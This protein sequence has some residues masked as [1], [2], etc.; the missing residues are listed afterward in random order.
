M[1]VLIVTGTS[2]GVGKTV[3]TA[4]LAAC[5]IAN[6]R[7]VTIVKLVQT[8]LPAG[9]PGDVAEAGRLSGCRHLVELLRYPDPLAPEAAA[10]LSRR[11]Y[12]DLATLRVAVADLASTG[13]LVLVE[14]AGGLL[15]RFDA[16]GRTL[17]DLAAM[18]S[19]P[20]VVV[21]SA[22]LGTLNH[23]ALTLEALDRRRIEL[24]G[25]ILG[26]WP[27]VP[28]LA[29]R[30]NLADFVS[31]VGEPLQGALPEGA[32]SASPD[33]FRTIAVAG[34]SPRF[35]GRFDMRDLDFPPIT[36]PTTEAEDPG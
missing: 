27:A 30:S 26:S 7:P 2:T 8:G 36:A 22:G 20:V 33:G 21:A 11:P 35:G 3:A 6:G 15:V 25:V 16:R 32:A 1:S 18:M 4:A 17:A 19:A 13:S 14:G 23:T 24:A 9:V 31:I 10:R 12:P 29:T 34:L 5:A 28:D